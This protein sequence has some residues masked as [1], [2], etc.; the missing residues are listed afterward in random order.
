MHAPCPMPLGIMVYSNALLHVS[1]FVVDRSE[2]MFTLR[3]GRT[4]THATEGLWK[5]RVLGGRDVGIPPFKTPTLNKGMLW[6][7]EIMRDRYHPKMLLYT[8]DK[9]FFVYAQI[10]DSPRD[11]RVVLAYEILCISS[12]RCTDR[13]NGVEQMGMPDA[14]AL[15]N[16]EDA[17][18]LEHLAWAIYNGALL[19]GLWSKLLGPQP[20]C[21]V[22]VGLQ[23]HIYRGHEDVAHCPPQTLG[24]W[25]HEEWVQALHHV[26]GLGRRR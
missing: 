16:T 9:L 23:R 7:V 6:A 1:L 21:T 8:L 24:S 14:L 10:R 15:L 22:L 26:G 2:A 18:H 25:D 4:F 5:T 20:W 12:S 3:T 17:R 19:V 11:E 13:Q